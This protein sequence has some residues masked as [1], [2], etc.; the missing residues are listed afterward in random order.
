MSLSKRSINSSFK[1]DTCRQSAEVQQTL[2]FGLRGPDRWFMRQRWIIDSEN[3]WP[4][5]SHEQLRRL[6]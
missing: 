1:L 3:S 2:I 5:Q 6:L 4:A